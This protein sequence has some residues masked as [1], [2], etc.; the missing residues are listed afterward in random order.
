M[1]VK[2]YKHFLNCP[3]NHLPEKEL[4]FKR[5]DFCHDLPTQDFNFWMSSQGT[6]LFQWDVEPVDRSVLYNMK[7]FNKHASS[8]WSSWTKPLL[9]SIL[10]GFVS[11]SAFA[12]NPTVEMQQ[13]AKNFLISLTKEQ[14]EKAAFG[15]EDEERLNWHFI[16]KERN[17]LTLKEMNSAQR[18][19]A[20][21]LLSSGLSARAYGQA[22]TVMRLEAILKDLENGSPTRDIDKYYFSIF[23]E[24]TACGSWGW[25]VEG[26]HLSVNFTIV[27]GSLVAA[28][29]SFYGSNPAEIRTGP[30][31]GLKVLEGEEEIGRAFMKSLNAEKSGKAVISDKAPGDVFS[32][33]KR[34]VDPLEIQGIQYKDLDSAQKEALEKVIHYYVNRL[35]PELA[36]AEWDAIHDAGL[37]TVQFAWMGS[38][39]RNEAH[40]YRVQG[41][42]FLLEYDNVQND[43]N[44]VHA[45]WRDFD[46]DFGIDLLA[47]HYK[48]YPHSKN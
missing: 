17:G 15:F 43:A 9:F 16:P 40:Y 45:T 1:G 35:R 47:E 14:T 12:G 19:H 6:D 48:N 25:R 34:F 4:L 33:G 26:H 42:T 23:G 39:V 31:T 21:V 5:V 20:H 13:A 24:P 44:H 37:E 32:G 29:P 8:S 41:P 46:G 7:L 27:D 38:L 30:H 3:L 2:D 28:T 22:L 10:T 11:F 36:E 18:L